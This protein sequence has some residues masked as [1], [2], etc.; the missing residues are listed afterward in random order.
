[1]RLTAVGARRVAVAAYFL[2]PGLL[3]DAVVTAAR[4]AGAVAVAE[5]LGTAPELVR[6]VLDRADAVSSALAAA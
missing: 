1:M 2:A 6:L 3:H 5:P 4:A